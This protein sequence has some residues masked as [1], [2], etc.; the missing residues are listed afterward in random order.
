MTVNN[1][2]YFYFKKALEKNNQ[3]QFS[4]EYVISGGHYG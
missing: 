3:V 2:N 4:P 1:E